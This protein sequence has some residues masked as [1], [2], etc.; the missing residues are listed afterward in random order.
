M[1]RAL[2]FAAA[3]VGLMVLFALAA[4]CLGA[5]ALGGLAFR[6]GAER[7]GMSAV[8][9]LGAL[10]TLFFLLGALGLF[11]PAVVA[12]VLAASF[13]IGWKPLLRRE[14]RR[15]GKRSRRSVAAR[16][17]LAAAA[18][19]VLAP[20]LLAAML[21]PL[22]A[23]TIMYHLP[24]A[25]E[26]ARMRSVG[27]LVDLRYPVFPQQ[28]ELFAA[29]GFLFGSEPFSALVNVL[30]CAL[31]AVLLAA[32]GR[33]IGSAGA[34]VL[35]VA[36]WIACPIVLFLARSGHVE[37]ATAGFA[38]AAILAVD[39]WTPDGDRRWLFAAGALAGWAAATKYTGLFFVAA[40]PLVL[41]AKARSS[42]R[43]QHLAA[44]LAAAFVAAGPWYARNLL[45]SGNPVWPF[46]GEVFGYRFWT[47]GDV[48]SAIWSLKQE[49]GPHT[50]RAFATLPVTLSWAQPPGV[51]RVTPALFPLFL[52][53]AGWM[54]ASEKRRWLGALGAGYVVFWFATT[55]QSRFLVPA[56]P[57]FALV[58]AEG[59][60]SLA[61]R[62][63]H[64]RP[65]RAV[66]L[67]VI[68]AASL[69]LL[70]FRHLSR[71]LPERLIPPIDDAERAAYLSL[72]LPS[73]PVYRKL[74]AELGSRYTIYA[75][76]D[77]PLEYYCEGTHLGDWFG[78]G[79]YGDVELSSGERLLQSLRRLGAQYLLVNATPPYETRLPH[80]AFFE[81][82]FEPIYE[83]GAIVAYRLR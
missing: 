37:L 23:D 27:A 31:V 82:H 66:L 70:P 53:G 38:T 76:H 12:V 54:A 75:F 29:A 78:K 61:R 14:R 44:F 59:T 47:A 62:L 30:W 72:R 22:D 48:A 50:L 83:R 25:R 26:F 69:S 24:A 42:T 67:T 13:A 33:R 79:R 80:D 40:L 46:F 18:A 35:S 60:V 56:L 5:R 71:L 6:R 77:E 51:G 8:F 49:G 81:R 63:L 55:Q 28:S 73:Y 74:N 45:L 20:L 41:V 11:H 21:P 57:L 16:V 43:V 10:G 9:G 65:V 64:R 7:L 4:C 17:G 2:P 1:I 39:A 36:L 58:G 52:V 19:A 32:W 34:G 15:A 68:G 3:H